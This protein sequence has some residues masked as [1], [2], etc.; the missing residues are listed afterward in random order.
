MSFLFAVDTCALIA[1]EHGD[2]FEEVV[3]SFNI[4][5]TKKVVDELEETAAFKD[6]DGEC[7]RNILSKLSMLK[8]EK[9]RARDSAEEELLELAR[10]NRVRY[11]VTDDL[12]AARK[13]RLSGMKVLFSPHLVY[14]LYKRGKLEKEDAVRTIE[15]MRYRR[16]WKENVIYTMALGLFE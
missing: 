11:I 8:V 7:A 1:L 6:Q 10:D 4:A 2:V 15:R 13:M 14:L 3:R 16:T 12:K 5:V 9:V